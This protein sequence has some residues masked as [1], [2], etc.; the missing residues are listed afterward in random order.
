MY[1]VPQVLAGTDSASF[2]SP[3]TSLCNQVKM[4]L[5][6]QNLEPNYSSV[7]FFLEMK[8]LYIVQA[9]FKLRLM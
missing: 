3:Y 4:L 1:K 9:G 6:A 2:S 8:S 5:M 7:S